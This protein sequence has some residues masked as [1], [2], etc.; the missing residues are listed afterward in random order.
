MTKTNFPSGA[1]LQFSFADVFSEISSLSQIAGEFIAPGGTDLVLPRLKSDLENIQSSGSYGAPIKWQIRRER[2]LNTTV[3]YGS[4]QRDDEGQLNVYGSMSFVWAIAPVELKRRVPSHFVLD[5][6]ASTELKLYERVPQGADRLLAS[7][8]V[9][10]AAHDSPGTHFHVQLHEGLNA[11]S[12]PKTLDVP[13]L[14]V[15]A[16]SPFQCFE[17]M[18]AELF[19][20]RWAQEAQRQNGAFHNWNRVQ[21]QRI[22]SFLQWQQQGLSSKTGTP[23]SILKALKPIGR[24]LFK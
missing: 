5:G 6:L 16:M 21:R 4:Y 20:E 19:Q 23:W 17:G 13:R 24:T 3:S 8:Q 12:L 15:F 7:W 18:V 9:D 2:T 10:V 22:E 11:P 14:P 1:C